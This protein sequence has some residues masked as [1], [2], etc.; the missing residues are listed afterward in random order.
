MLTP[1]ALST[2]T[3]IQNFGTA[4]NGNFPRSTLIADAGG[5]LYGTAFLSGPYLGGN[6]VL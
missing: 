1:P 2:E 6:D 4:P 5:N 3:V